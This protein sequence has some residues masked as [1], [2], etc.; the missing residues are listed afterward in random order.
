M[1][2]NHLKPDIPVKTVPEVDD[3][4]THSRPVLLTSLISIVIVILLCGYIGW[5]E[6][7]TKIQ[8]TNKNTIFT[9]NLVASHTGASLKGLEK[10]LI[11]MERE[12]QL[13]QFE[14]DQP[15]NPLIHRYLLDLQKLYTELMDVLILDASGQITHWTGTDTPPDTSSRQYALQHIQNTDS[16]LYISEPNLSKV[17]D[18][19]WFFALSIPIR[20]TE[21]NL[22]RILVAIIDIKQ[23]TAQ[24]K[25]IQLPEMATVGIITKSGNLITRIPNHDQHVGKNLP[26]LDQLWLNQNEMGNFTIKSRLD[27][28][29]RIVGYNMIKAFNLAALSTSSKKI[30]LKPWLKGI[31]VLGTIVLF[32]ILVIIY[33][34]RRIL[35]YQHTVFE[36]QQ[37]LFALATTDSLTG[38]YNRRYCLELLQQ[39]VVRSKRYQNPL[40]FLMIDIDYFKRV[41]D[42]YGHVV[43]D[44]ALKKIAETLLTT[45]RQGDIVSRYGGEEF[46]IV[47]PETAL[48]EASGLAERLRNMT[49]HSPV[50]IDNAELNLTISI[51]VSSFSHLDDHKGME[52]IINEADQAMYH[53][54]NNGRNRVFMSMPVNTPNAAS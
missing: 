15:F 23:L 37:Q 54:K 30:V 36:Q 17:H 25:N 16:S 51:G 40:S 44:M 41:N 18:N 49:Q 3:S 9:A 2:L 19:Q 43:G 48:V 38:T 12:L 33:L 13:S 8:Q 45:C 22:Q 39:E 46:F 34:T 24:F 7:H 52:Q 50:Q 28:A 29:E 35:R 27:G 53:A 6:Y 14:I 5:S 4:I 47:L 10:M 21:S 26:G 42:E 1:I 32:I 31:Q 11:S 20:D